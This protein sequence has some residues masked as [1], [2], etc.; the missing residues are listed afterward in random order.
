ML[1]KEYRIKYKNSTCTEMPI[2]EDIFMAGHCKGGQ[3][4]KL[5]CGCPVEYFESNPN[6]VEDHDKDAE[7]IDSDLGH[8]GHGSRHRRILYPL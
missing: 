7:G 2:V 6:F 8:V 5:A 4:G 3:S 1:A